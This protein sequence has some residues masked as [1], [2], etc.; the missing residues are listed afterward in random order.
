MAE[1]IAALTKANKKSSFVF[2]LHAGEHAQVYNEITML[3]K[4]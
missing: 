3:I 2:Y 1:Q 4:L